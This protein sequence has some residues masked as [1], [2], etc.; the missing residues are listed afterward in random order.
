MR[1]A[2]KNNRKITFYHGTDKVFDHFDDNKL[3]LNTDHITSVLGHFF[4]TK[5][6]IARHYGSHL[7]KVNIR[8]NKVMKI[9]L[10][11]LQSFNSKDEVISYRNSLIKNNID[12]LV[13][14]EC[15]YIISLHG[16][17]IKI[18]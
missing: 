13:I 2:T 14:P 3:G 7:M 6:S 5:K 9:S 11:K 16:N 12:L 15:N 10:D 1:Y 18:I 17:N 8:Y 4:T